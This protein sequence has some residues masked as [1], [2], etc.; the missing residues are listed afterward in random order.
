MIRILKAMIETGGH[1]LG[2]TIRDHKV[3]FGF[4]LDQ[5]K[6]P[7]DLR[8]QLHLADNGSGKSCG[9]SSNRLKSLPFQERG[10]ILRPREVKG[11]T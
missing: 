8:Y 11:G 6:L 3:E 5:S 10:E 1:H 2:T 7:W 4:D 9:H